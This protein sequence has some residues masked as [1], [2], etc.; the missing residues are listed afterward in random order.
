MNTFIRLFRN[1]TTDAGGGLGALNP[2]G[3]GL[4]A[5]ELGYGIIQDIGAEKRQKA[6][7]KRRKAYKTPDEI[8]DIL[9]ATEYNAQTGYDPITL[10]YLTDQTNQ[11]FAS[12]IG[13]A[14][15]L[16]ADP[17]AL[18]AIFGQ[19][20]DNIR[21]ISA[22]NHSLY[23]QNFGNYINALNT[24][25][26]ND[27]AEQKSAQDMIND[28]LQAAG[29]DLKSATGNIS[30]GINTLLATASAN[31]I[32]QLYNADGT[33]RTPRLR[34]Q[35]YLPTQRNSLLFDNRLPMGNY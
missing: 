28:E 15:R 26:S 4:G 34:K 10:N 23:M 18:S 33:L 14:E 1:N 12:S 6:A 22:D 7:L 35:G 11:S 21:R 13:A 30:G 19:N 27:A 20:V 8:F 2:I 16:G 29:A 25:A 32:S 17:N 3:L 31:Q 24:V 9:N 5:L